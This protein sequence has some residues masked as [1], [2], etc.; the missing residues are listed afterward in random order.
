M[1]DLATGMDSGDDSELFTHRTPYQHKRLSSDNQTFLD[2]VEPEAQDRS[3]QSQTMDSSDFA[4]PLNTLKPKDGYSSP[5]GELSSVAEEAESISL[6]SSVSASILSMPDPLSSSSR[7][8]VQYDTIHISDYA[9]IIGYENNVSSPLVDFN[10]T[11]ATMNPPSEFGRRLDD[12]AP[13]QQPELAYLDHSDHD[14][15]SESEPESESSFPS[16]TSSFFFSSP[17]SVASHVPGDDSHEDS[18]EDGESGSFRAT[19]ELVI[20]SLMLPTA[21]DLPHDYPL[22]TPHPKPSIQRLQTASASNFLRLLVVAPSDSRRPSEGEDG[23]ISSLSERVKNDLDDVASQTIGFQPQAVRLESLALPDQDME[24]VLAAIVDSFV[25]NELFTAVV[26]TSEMSSD[27]VSSIKHEIAQ[28]SEALSP[29]IPV[30]YLLYTRAINSS[31]TSKESSSS[32]FAARRLSTSLQ[33]S[34][35]I[36]TAAFSVS[37][38]EEL[39]LLSQRPDVIQRLRTEAVDKFMKWTAR[40]Q[41]VQE[42]TRLDDAPI[43]IAGRRARNRRAHGEDITSS[44]HIQGDTS[45]SASWNDRSRSEGGWRQFKAEWEASW[46]D[47]YSMQRQSHFSLE[48]GSQSY[49]EEELLRTAR[50]RSAEPPS[51]VRPGT[52]KARRQSR[53]QRTSFARPY[54]SSSSPLPATSPSLPPSSALPST[55]PSSVSLPDSLFISAD[56]IP[57]TPPIPP[58]SLLMAFPFPSSTVSLLPSSRNSSRARSRGATSGSISPYYASEKFASHS[59]PFLHDLRFPSFLALSLSIL[60]PLRAHAWSA[61]RRIFTIPFEVTRNL[62]IF[63][64]YED[65]DQ[66]GDDKLVG[67]IDSIEAIDNGSGTIESSSTSFYQFQQRLWPTGVVLVGGFL[68]GF[69]VG[70]LRAL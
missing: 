63:D 69:A 13:R 4:D 28:F 11:S 19:R 64:E 66:S 35:L 7:T 41:K 9:S 68:L 58:I 50:I 46:E 59:T 6:P 21:L 12:F 37:S 3:R 20:P 27:A 23:P 30:I 16:V 18:N 29:L 61:T 51:S 31:S 70:Y 40:R 65:G 48:I 25:K 15:G 45:A 38:L 56:E 34:P 32:H 26:L 67:S 62:S 22:E 5:R 55:M 1:M 17:A 42:N 24:G 54:S 14:V 43:S 53:H 39:Y 60:A 36:P 47:A 57:N 10:A 33:N 52:M 8:S 49:S 2:A 44:G